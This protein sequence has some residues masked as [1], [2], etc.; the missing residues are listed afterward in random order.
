MAITKFPNTAAGKA[1]AE[2]IPDPKYITYG[3]RILVFTGADIPPDSAIVDPSRL[4]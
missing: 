4:S 3:A 2:A 1:Q